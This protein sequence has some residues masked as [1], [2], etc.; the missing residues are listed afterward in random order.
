MTASFRTVENWA[1]YTFG[2]PE[3]KV[4]G[5]KWIARHGAR[6]GRKTSSCVFRKLGPSKNTGC[7][8]GRG[9]GT[10]HNE[11]EDRQSSAQRGSEN[12]RL[13]RA[14]TARAWPTPQ[15]KR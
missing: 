13:S 10:E 7:A 6:A 12:L 14:A 1:D 15:K 2:C 8:T 4:D 3:G 5:D 11:N 9:S